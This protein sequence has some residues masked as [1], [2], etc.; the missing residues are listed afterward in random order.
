MKIAHHLLSVGVW[1]FLAGCINHP[2]TPNEKPSPV[3]STQPTPTQPSEKTP[4]PPTNQPEAT[5]PEAT[6]PEPAK[7][8][9]KEPESYVACGCG[10]CGME[11][12]VG[13][14]VCIYRSKGESLEKIQKEDEKSRNN[15]R[16]A[17]VGCSLG[18]KYK[19]CD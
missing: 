9:T 3:T 1:L 13:R 11:N 16:C 5:K 2:P 14:E 17:T 8:P 12:S 15:P 19:Y 7:T 6:K 18:T 4:E 10:C